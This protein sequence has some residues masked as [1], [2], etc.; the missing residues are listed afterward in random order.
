MK[1]GAAK[2]GNLVKKNQ[3]GYKK[4]SENLGRPLRP[5]LDFFCQVKNGI[6]FDLNRKSCTWSICLLSLWQKMDR[7]LPST[8]N[9][10]HG[11]KTARSK[12]KDNQLIL[13]LFS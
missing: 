7:F 13:I 12:V 4:P 9:H 3:V 8:E 6:F 1:L 2:I 10:G 11:L 5:W